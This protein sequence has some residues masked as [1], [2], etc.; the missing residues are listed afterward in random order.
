MLSTRRSLPSIS[1]VAAACLLL[2][3]TLALTGCGRRG[4]E[5]AKEK[6]R[7]SRHEFNAADFVKAAADGDRPLVEA[8]LQGGMDHNAVDARGLTALMAAAAAGKTDTVKALLDDN[9]KADLANKDGK[10]ALHLAAENNQPDAVRALIE[11]NADVRARDH[12]GISPL[13]RAVQAGHER[14]VAVFLD[15]SRDALAR[16]GQLDRG[17]AVASILGKVPII[18]LFLKKGANINA[19]VENKKTPLM[20]AAEYGQRPAVE[21][22]LARG[23]DARLTD[24]DSANASVIALQKGNPDLA[25]ILEAGLPPGGVKPTAPVTA[26]ATP[27]PAASATPTL[28]EALATPPPDPAEAREQTWLKEKGVQP[29]DAAGRDNGRSD[30]APLR[31]VRVSEEAFPVVFESVAA[32]GDR[33][34]VNVR[35]R[36][37]VE[38][39][40]GNKIPGTPYRVEK[41]RRRGISEKDTARQL[42]VSEL[43]L[44]N[45]DTKQHV[46]L[47]RGMPSNGADGRATLRPS[48]DDAEVTVRQGEQFTLPRDP[49]TRYEVV[50]IRP[51][52]VILKIV[53]TDR[54][55]TVEK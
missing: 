37:G 17:L 12:D 6:I 54:T 48:S 8:F 2:I 20:L 9:A 50:D 39:D 33:V 18:E 21:L 3:L 1:L 45:T 36:S 7:Q 25:K 55:V 49:A 46:V 15:T 47:V 19:T 40:V 32:K 31:L 42:D 38:V 27:P 11:A 29:G 35:G 30:G 52:Q 28:A 24:Q 22:L 44:T 10:T 41:M 53:G 26:N 4:R 14:V 23:A 51:T 13:L 5:A 34:T 43:T 16:D